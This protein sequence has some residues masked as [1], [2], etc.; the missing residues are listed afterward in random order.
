MRRPRV[1]LADD[2]AVVA[3]ALAAY[4]REACDL[5]AQV[6][7]GRDLVAAAEKHRPDLVIADM[8][9]PDLSGLEAM[10]RLRS[11]GSTA[12]F[13][14]LTMHE[15]PQLAGEALRAGASGYLVKTSAGEDLLKAVSEVMRGGVY[16]THAIAREALDAVA[17]PGSS[18]LDK[19]TLRQREVLRLV[20]AGRSMKEIAAALG[21]SPRTVETHKYEMMRS[22]KVETTAQLIQFA[23]RSGLVQL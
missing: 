18:P 7:G 8:S 12:K 16:L 4:L 17:T 14:F 22:L 11:A 6:R 2:H 1:I 20:A 23:I 19:L 5:V 15:D 13:I 3:D 21:L 10:R 9:M